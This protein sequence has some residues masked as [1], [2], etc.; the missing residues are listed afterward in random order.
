M[1]RLAI[2]LLTSVLIGLNSP[3]TLTERFE[4]LED[5]LRAKI[6]YHERGIWAGGCKK[7]KGEQDTINHERGRA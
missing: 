1:T 7:G 6:Y 3:F 5:C 4:T 2:Y